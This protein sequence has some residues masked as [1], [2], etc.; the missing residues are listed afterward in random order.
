MRLFITGGSGFVGSAVVPELRDAGHAVVALARS[1]ASASAL[2]A[3]GAEVV[4]GDL[5]DLDALRSSAA[6]AD[7]VV[8]L[9]FKHDEAF[10]GRFEDAA[11]ADARAIEALGDALAGSDRP[12]VITAGTL[13]IA[14]P[15]VV[16]TERDRLAPGPGFAA[17]AAGSQAALALADRAVRAAIVRLPPT[18]H[19]E[20]DQGFVPQVIAAARRTGAVSHVGD[21][22]NRWPAVHRLD[23]ARLFRL[24]VE[25]AP[26]GSVL[27]AV[28]EE[29][30]PFR[31]IAA[32]IADG[33]DLPLRSETPEQAAERY[34]FLAHVVSADAPAS[35]ALTRELL[36]WEPAGPGLLDDL[37]AGGYLSA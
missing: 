22:A 26:A 25:S 27:H 21:G 28:A 8:H 33:L 13:G 30:V 34:G 19:G 3:A 15:G 20:G 1:E 10:S 12:L 36:G 9:A 6:A 4:R 5:D 11:A 17:R 29:G 16:G 32:T 31:E 35:S 7:G 14:A 2:A 23:A 18:V 37:R 24:A